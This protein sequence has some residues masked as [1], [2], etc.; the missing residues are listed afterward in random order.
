MVLMEA[1]FDFSFPNGPSAKLVEVSAL[2]KK[3]IAGSQPI[4]LNLGGLERDPFD[5]REVNASIL[6]ICHAEIR[7]CHRGAIYRLALG[8]SGLHFCEMVKMGPMP[9]RR[10]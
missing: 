6:D 2:G 4:S 8:D 3:N 10:Q 1:Q 5:D 9:S 7:K